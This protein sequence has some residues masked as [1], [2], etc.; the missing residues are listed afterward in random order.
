MAFFAAFGLASG[1][2]SSLLFVEFL[3]ARSETVAYLAV[4][5]NQI[6]EV[7]S[8]TEECTKAIDFRK[9]TQLKPLRSK[10]EIIKPVLL[11]KIKSLPKIVVPTQVPVPLRKGTPVPVPKT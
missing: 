9:D 5:K 7:E 3:Q 11:P 4:I 2:M 10:I 8:L 1:A 6:K